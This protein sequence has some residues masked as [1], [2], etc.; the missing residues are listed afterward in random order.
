MLSSHETL[1]GPKS[2][3]VVF[4]NA[5]ESSGFVVD[6]SA[7]FDKSSAESLDAPSA[8]VSESSKSVAD[9]LDPV[10]NRSEPGLLDPPL[11]YVSS[12]S[13]IYTS[14]LTPNS[15]IRS[16]SQLSSIPPLDR[17]KSDPTP[18]PTQLGSQI[19]RPSSVP[20]KMNEMDHHLRLGKDFT[21][22]KLAEIKKAQMD[23]KPASDT[24]IIIKCFKLLF[25]IIASFTFA[26]NSFFG[27]LRFYKLLF[28][29]FTP[30]KN[31]AEFTKNGLEGV[32]LGATIFACIAAIA[33]ELVN[34]Y[35]TY[36]FGQRAMTNIKKLMPIL[37][38]VYR[39]EQLTRKEK[40]ILSGIV[41][42]I[43][44]AAGA[45]KLSWDATSK[46]PEWYFR[47]LMGILG[48]VS[49]FSMT[50]ITR[51]VT[52]QKAVENTNWFYANPA[53][54]Q[55]LRLLQKITPFHSAKVS[56]TLLAIMRTADFRTAKTDLIEALEKYNTPSPTN[57]DCALAAYLFSLSQSKIPAA[58]IFAFATTFALV[59]WLIYMDKD[60]SLFPDIDV[61]ELAYSLWETFKDT[62][63][64]IASSPH[65]FFFFYSASVI[66]GNIIT[67]LSLSPTKT[68]VTL[69]LMALVLPTCLG[70]FNVSL[71]MEQHNHIFYPMPSAESPR[72][73]MYAI[74]SLFDAFWPNLNTMLSMIPLKDWLAAQEKELAM[75][76]YH[77]TALK[78]INEEPTVDEEQKMLESKQ[79]QL[80][81]VP[82]IIDISPPRSDIVEQKHIPSLSPT[83]EKQ[84]ET[85]SL[86]V[87]MTEFKKA[88]SAI[89]KRGFFS[90]QPRQDSLR[91]PLLAAENDQ[92]VD[93]SERGYVGKTYDYIRSWCGPRRASR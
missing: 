64:A 51:S 46:S 12:E 66:L 75:N 34:V 6:S 29:S 2:Q 48:V 92:L 53:K 68:L 24:S 30:P 63:S 90:V 77:Q 52:A 11:H 61:G 40:G 81:P 5:D 58:L 31:L 13:S 71:D 36:D 79:Q 41:V 25:A 56:L 9:P 78:I 67:S 85:R 44:A 22:D 38:K 4:V 70:L 23:Q 1:E 89:V 16:I 14:S 84:S 65:M 33:S 26:N 73:W 86:S 7:P 60:A 69:G 54:A 83:A 28:G 21:E 15:L 55:L 82:L 10:S 74:L 35:Q 62:I 20:N 76:P 72:G 32:P 59:G 91:Q 49:F 87:I 50:L 93:P 37:E 27:G 80:D 3:P 47:L 18:P 43:G 8:P 39:G 57:I 45:A 17:S 42:S 19:Y 88:E